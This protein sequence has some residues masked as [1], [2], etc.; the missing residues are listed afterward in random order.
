MSGIGSNGAYGTPVNIDGTTA[1]PY[2]PG[3]VMWTAGKWWPLRNPAYVTA[4]DLNQQ[5]SSAVSFLAQKPSFQLAQYAAQ[6]VASGADTPLT[7]DTEISDGWG[8]HADDTDTSQVVIP[9]GCDGIWLVQGSV[10]YNTTVTGHYF[11]SQIIYTP[12][13]GA[14]ATIISGERLQANGAHVAPNV[15]DLI[16]VQ[17]GDVLQLGALQSSGASAYTWAAETTALVQRFN[18]QAAPVITG[19]WVAANNSLPGGVLPVPVPAA[20]VGNTP[21]MVTAGVGMAIPNLPYWSDDDQASSGVF[22]GYIA[23]TTLFLSNVPAFRVQAT[24]T[25]P[26]F[27][28]GARAQVT[29]LQSTIDNWSAWDESTSTWTCPLSGAYLVYGQVGWP[30]VGTPF[31]CGTDF[32]CT[33]SGTSVAYYGANA[34]GG[35]PASSMLRHLR[36]SKGDTVQL[37]GNQSSGSPLTL[38]GQTNTRLFALWV[39]A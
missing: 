19:R 25:L 23:G 32:Q 20:W 38:A 4:Q 15:A 11:E 24:G 28:S 8:M 30:N 39:S 26:S 37:W 33:V 18:G 7:L 27:S 14:A 6:A 17:A 3:P 29:G 36:F 13:S 34:Y 31:V 9:A 12:A 16:A 22:N 21:V 1:T 10:P 35:A 5:I 2:P